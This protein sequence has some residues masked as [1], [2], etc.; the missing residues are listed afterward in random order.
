M[1]AQIIFGLPSAW[2]LDRGAWIVLAFGVSE[3]DVRGHH[4]GGTPNL[5]NA[6]EIF[7]QRGNSAK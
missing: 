3:K 4:E 7:G 6:I 1:R 2:S 5:F